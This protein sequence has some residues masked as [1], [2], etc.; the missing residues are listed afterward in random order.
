[1]A[2]KQTR[3][4]SLSTT[5]AAKQT[6]R[7]S[8][9]LGRFLVILV[10]CALSCEVSA[11]TANQKAFRSPQGKHSPI[12]GITTK[13]PS[14]KPNLTEQ[15]MLRD[16]GNP[17]VR[18]A[19]RKSSSKLSNSVLASCDTLP[20]FPTAHGLLSPETVMRIEDLTKRGHGSE[21]LA[22]FL[23]QYR[24]NGPLSCVS[25]LSDP[26]ILPHLTKAMRDI[27]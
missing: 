4:H 17:R 16:A 9:A 8:N 19:Q 20:S 2:A 5:M 1:M 7:A 13:E 25:M 24:K 12:R 21:A 6:Q 27:S 22:N 15:K 14:Q 3:R 18:E 10:L 23:V 26:Q 11:W